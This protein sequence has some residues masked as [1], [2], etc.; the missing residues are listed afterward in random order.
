MCLPVA[1]CTTTASPE[2]RRGR[3]TSAPLPACHLPGCNQPDPVGKDNWLPARAAP[4]LPQLTG[5]SLLSRR[6]NNRFTGLGPHVRPG[7]GPGSFRHHPD[8]HRP[9]C[10]PHPQTLRRLLILPREDSSN[11]IH[12][13]QTDMAWH[14]T[15]AMPYRAESGLGLHPS[16]QS[17]PLGSRLPWPRLELLRSVLSQRNASPGNIDRRVAPGSAC[18]RSP[19][20]PLA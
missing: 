10:S 18:R 19:G 15:P 11:S 1:R 12:R 13:W 2:S 6:S 4:T 14:T 20:N 8:T 5:L 17:S 3:F 9:A 16:P 7:R